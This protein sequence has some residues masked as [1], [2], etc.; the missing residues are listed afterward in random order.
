MPRMTDS[1][2]KVMF[3]V[4]SVLVTLTH[5]T[6]TS[7][8][9]AVAGCDGRSDK[10]ELQDMTTAL[11]HAHRCMLKDEPVPVPIPLNT[12]PDLIVP[13]HIIVPRCSGLCL[14]SLGSSCSPKKTKLESHSVVV[15]VNSTPYCTSIELEHHRGPCKCEC[16]LNQA[17]C[18]NRQI[19][20]SDTC[21][22]QCLPGLTREKLE[23]VNST[24][25]IWDSDT[26]QCT[27][28]YKHTCK[29]GQYFDTATCSCHQNV[30]NGKLECS[31]HTDTSTRVNL[32]PL[33]VIIMAVILF[34]LL[35]TSLSFTIS[36]RWRRETNLHRPLEPRTKAYTITLCSNQS[37]DKAT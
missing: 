34:L 11:L 13:S 15:Y 24:R 5:A 2:R 17:S 31:N 19:F 16:S 36:Y 7:S 21:K 33:L 37:L 4:V 35:I 22:C 8:L 26:C 14:N 18:N 1:V 12:I 29:Y 3:C 10:K 27:C 25:H 6:P 28:K 20:L 9:V 30:F 23:C 32:Y